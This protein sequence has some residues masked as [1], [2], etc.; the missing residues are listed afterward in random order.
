V[1][2]P[3][4]TTCSRLVAAGTAALAV[5]AALLASPAAATT[6][7]TAAA[8]SGSGGSVSA[9]RAPVEA[10]GPY[11]RT[12]RSAYVWSI[13]PVTAARLGVSH[14]AGCPVAAGD[15]RLV[16][17]TSWGFDG[18]TRR[19]ELVVHRDVAADTVKI[20]RELHAA[21]FPLMRVVTTEQYGADD[22]RLMAA[23]ATSAYN[24]RATTG[25]TGFSEHAYGRAIDLNPIQN[26]YVRGTT[27]EPPAGRA[28]LDRDAV[29]PGMVVAGDPV[30]RAFAAVGW[31]WGGDFRTLKDYQHFSRSGRWTARVGLGPTGLALVEP[32]TSVGLG[33]PPPLG[34]GERSLREG[35]ALTPQEHHA[36]QRR[37]QHG[38]ADREQALEPDRQHQPEGH[39]QEQ[40]PERGVEQEGPARTHRSRRPRRG[41]G[42]GRGLRLGGHAPRLATGHPTPGPGFP[43]LRT[44]PSGPADLVL[45]CCPCPRRL[46]ATITCARFLCT[47]TR[48]FARGHSGGDRTMD[49][50]MA[51]T[52]TETLADQG[53][54]LTPGEVAAMFRVDPKT[55]TRWA[56]AGRIGSIRTPGGHRRFRE[57]EVRALLTNGRS[58]APAFTG[59]TNGDASTAEKIPVQPV[60]DHDA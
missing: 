29:R 19:G 10:V 35:V 22:D 50:T 37:D 25:G 39:Q 34:A 1:L 21:R 58:V 17:V 48:D 5:T 59:N 8:T 41:L 45:V 24:C 6:G 60:A 47:S 32:R 28:Y 4:R 36:Q 31:R 7:G 27:V 20:F 51:E 54:L 52:T 42:G 53:R 57:T 13:R 9:A 12:A 26:P 38:R 2:T 3:V 55:V 44:G 43:R 40:Q 16:G 33:G 56:A 15:L 49:E 18:R 14:R 23:N 30:V 11:R 46:S